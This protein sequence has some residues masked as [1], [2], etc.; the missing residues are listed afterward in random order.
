MKKLLLAVIVVIGSAGYILF[1]RAGNASTIPVVVPALGVVDTNTPSPAP[2]QTPANTV[3]TIPVATKPSPVP[4]PAPTPVKP[5]ATGKYK[6][7]T[8]TGSVADAYYGNIQVAAV[9]SGGRL[10]SVKVLQYPN[11][12][13][14]SVE[15]N[16]QALP[17]LIQ[18]AISAQS[19][20]VD[21]IS[22]ASDTSAAFS[23]SLGVALGKA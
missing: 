7:G 21:G 11:D 23:E 10:T 13:N 4:T 18:Q 6:D 12:R 14:T 15:I 17:M 20:N 1:S 9:I 22:G 5:V 3:H 19:A 2:V 16:Q 8:Y